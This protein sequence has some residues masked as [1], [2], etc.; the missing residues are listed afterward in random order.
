MTWALHNHHRPIGRRRRALSRSLRS[1]SYG[2]PAVEQ[3]LAGSTREVLSGPVRF[4]PEGKAF[5]F[6][7]AA[8]LD[9]LLT[10]GRCN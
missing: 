8:V 4:R 10:G 7:G 3:T 9:Q 6:E 1:G 2:R 5:R